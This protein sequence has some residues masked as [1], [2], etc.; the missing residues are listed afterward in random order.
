MQARRNEVALRIREGLK[1]DAPEYPL[2]VALSDLYAYYRGGTLVGALVGVTESMAVRA[3]EA[4]DR[5]NA[6]VVPHAILD[7]V[8]TTVSVP[9]APAMPPRIAPGPGQACGGLRGLDTGPVASALRRWLAAAPDSAE[10]RNRRDAIEREARSAG[11]DC[12]PVDAQSFIGD[13]RPAVVPIKAQVVRALQVL[14]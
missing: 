6:S 10:R 12:V 7:R 9:P 4:R 11:Y 5:L 3:G 14:P 1:L 2:G 8:Q 13:T